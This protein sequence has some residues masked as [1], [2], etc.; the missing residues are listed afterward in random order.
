LATWSINHMAK[1][2]N[3]KKNS[4]KISIFEKII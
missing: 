4:K 1:I 2:S 3:L